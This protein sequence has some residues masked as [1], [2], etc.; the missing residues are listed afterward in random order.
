MRAV[1]GR[2]DRLRPPALAGVAADEEDVAVAAVAVGFLVVALLVPAGL[3]AAFFVP[4]GLAEVGPAAFLVAAPARVRLGRVAFLPVAFVPVAFVP[5]A[6][7]PVPVAFVAEGAPAAPDLG[8][9]AGVDPVAADA[10][11]GELVDV[12]RAGATVRFLL[13]PRRCAGPRLSVGSDG[14]PVMVPA[15]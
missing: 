4:A 15:W 7:V 10:A 2:R 11:R 8:R 5:V 13:G 6:L 1:A 3:V 14:P 9:R 12:R